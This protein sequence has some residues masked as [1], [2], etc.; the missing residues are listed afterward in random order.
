[1]FQTA[2]TREQYQTV[3][4]VQLTSEIDIISE[5]VLIESCSLNKFKKKKL[6]HKKSANKNVCQNA[7][8]TNEHTTTP[9]LFKSFFVSMYTKVINRSVSRSTP[10]IHPL[11]YSPFNGTSSFHH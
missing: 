7:V 3:K 6:K 5:F 8:K 4:A 11:V 1:M 10:K 9:A 2:G